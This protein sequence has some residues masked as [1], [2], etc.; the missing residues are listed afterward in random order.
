MNNFLSVGIYSLAAVG[1]IAWVWAKAWTL[2]SAPDTH[3]DGDRSKKKAKK[4]K[5]K[6]GARDDLTEISGIG[7]VIS[8]KL[9]KLGYTRFE[10]IAGFTK[11]DIARVNEQLNFKGRIEREKWVSQAKKLVHKKNNI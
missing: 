11:Q 1:F 8:G 10:Q 9:Y 3:S 2:N 7:K 6:K 4:K 5:A